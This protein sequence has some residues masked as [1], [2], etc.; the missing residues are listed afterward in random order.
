MVRL[1]ILARKNLLELLADIL[2]TPLAINSPGKI[3]I[4]A[5]S[6]LCQESDEVEK[7]GR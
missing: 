2:I 7:R 5:R 4:Q 1:S 6:L 3:G